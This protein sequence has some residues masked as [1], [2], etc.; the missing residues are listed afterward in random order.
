[1]SAGLSVGTDA[2]QGEYSTYAPKGEKCRRC[3]KPFASLEPV[4]RVH[5]FG[6]ATGRPYVH[7][8]CRAEVKS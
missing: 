1:V 4:E 6:I 8:D 7:P 5:P 3:H 2:Q